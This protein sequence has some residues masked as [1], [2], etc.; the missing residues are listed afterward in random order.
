[1]LG[2]GIPSGQVHGREG[3]DTLAQCLL[4]HGVHLLDGGDAL[5]HQKCRR[6]EYAFKYGI[7]SIAVTAL[8]PDRGL[9]DLLVEFQNEIRH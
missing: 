2:D 7:N 8:D 5:F 4:N 9:A 6:K 1:M 3:P